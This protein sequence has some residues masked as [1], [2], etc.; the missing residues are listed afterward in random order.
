MACRLVWALFGGR[1]VLCFQQHFD[2]PGLLA[3]QVQTR[4][5]AGPADVEDARWCLHARGTSGS[6]AVRGCSIL[7]GPPIGMEAESGP[8]TT[9][10]RRVPYSAD[11]R[12]CSNYHRGRFLLSTI[13]AAHRLWHVRMCAARRRTAFAT[14]EWPHIHRAQCSRLLLALGHQPVVLP[15]LPPWLG[16]G[17]GPAFAPAALLRGPV[18][19][20]RLPVHQA[21]DAR[22][23]LLPSALWVPVCLLP[24]QQVLL[25]GSHGIAGTALGNAT[26]IIDDDRS[27][28]TAACLCEATVMC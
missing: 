1:M 28:K 19:H 26:T 15:R 17:A 14:T 13:A 8:R 18:W 6:A 24:A 21:A 4:Q 10:Q 27:V 3:Q 7:E 2:R 12:L 20:H 5:R 22:R 9:F 23:P 16:S 11:W 25:G